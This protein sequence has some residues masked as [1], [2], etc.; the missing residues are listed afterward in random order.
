MICVQSGEAMKRILDCFMEIYQQ[1]GLNAFFHGAFSSILCA[2]GGAQVLV[3]CDKIKEFFPRD[4]S[5]CSSGSDES[6]E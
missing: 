3:L 4:A 5:D 1:E 2:T 6:S